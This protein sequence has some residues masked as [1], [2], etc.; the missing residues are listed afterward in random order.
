MEVDGTASQLQRHPCRRL[1]V[2]RQGLPDPLLGPPQRLLPHV[3]HPHRVEDT[4]NETLP[5]VRTGD[6]S[7]HSH[8]RDSADTP[9]RGRGSAGALAQLPWQLLRTCGRL[10]RSRREPGAVR[11]PRG[12]GGDRTHHQEPALLRQPDMALPQRADGGIYRRLRERHHQDTGGRTQRGSLL[13]P[14]PPARAAAEDE[15]SAAAH[16]Q[17]AGTRQNRRDTHREREP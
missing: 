5:A 3:R 7:A 2:G 17:L 15:H 12:D 16:R 13:P 9:W 10:S 14:R 1:S 11:A 4:H 8:S 6:V